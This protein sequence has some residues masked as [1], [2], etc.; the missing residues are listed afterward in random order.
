MVSF[1]IW[2]IEALKKKL[3]EETCSV[4]LRAANDLLISLIALLLLNS[5]KKLD[6]QN[7]RYIVDIL[8]E[9]HMLVII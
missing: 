2:H 5:I 4:K 3:N 7:L 9:K 8:F 6:I 1:Q